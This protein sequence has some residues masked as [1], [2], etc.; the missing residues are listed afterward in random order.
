MSLARCESLALTAEDRRKLILSGAIKVPRSLF[1]AAQRMDQ[2]FTDYDKL[3][4]T[5]KN[6]MKGGVGG[7]PIARAAIVQ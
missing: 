1:I 4:I 6:R 3:A 2:K 5:D 7:N